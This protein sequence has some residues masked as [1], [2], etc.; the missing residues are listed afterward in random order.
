M[1]AEWLKKMEYCNHGY[2][3]LLKWWCEPNQQVRDKSEL[4]K[5]KT[6]LFY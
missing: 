1:G 5:Q 6:K 4:N 3:R 2:D